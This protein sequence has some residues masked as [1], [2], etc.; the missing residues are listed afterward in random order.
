[1]TDHPT[2]TFHEAEIADYI[3][4]GPRRAANRDDLEIAAAYEVF[5]AHVDANTPIGMSVVET[6]GRELVAPIVGA[7]L[8]MDGVE[9]TFTAQAEG[10]NA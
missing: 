3:P 2:A 5:G 7:L 1:M 10:T 9:I 4:T 6:V 8:A